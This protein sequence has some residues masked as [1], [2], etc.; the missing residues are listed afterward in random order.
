MSLKTFDQT[1]KEIDEHICKINE[2]TRIINA[3]DRKIQWNKILLKGVADYY[4]SKNSNDNY[5]GD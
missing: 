4:D 5:T 3:I 1:I 2:S